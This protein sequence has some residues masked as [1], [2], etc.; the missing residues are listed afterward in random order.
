MKKDQ[1]G[2][3]NYF[4]VL[5]FHYRLPHIRN[6]NKIHAKLYIPMIKLF[7]RFAAKTTLLLWPV[8]LN[9]VYNF[10]ICEYV[11][12]VRMNIIKLSSII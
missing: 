11:M 6:N 4:F 5:I 2:S 10:N 7:F 12:S 1:E 3:F 9:G 8:D